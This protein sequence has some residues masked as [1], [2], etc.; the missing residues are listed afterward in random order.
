MGDEELRDPPLC[1]TLHG[2]EQLRR[3]RLGQDRRRLVED[4]KARVFL[5]HLAGD[6]DELHVSHGKA[7][8]R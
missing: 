6:F 1:Q 5:V 4:Q 7:P 2:V 3:F 8:D